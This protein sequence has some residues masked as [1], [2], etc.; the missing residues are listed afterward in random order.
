MG[1]VDGSKTRQPD[2]NSNMDAF[3]IK[4][5]CIV[6]CSDISGRTPK[7]TMS[8]IG[9]PAPEEVPGIFASGC[10]AIRGL[11]KQVVS[12]S[13][14]YDKTVG[15]DGDGITGAET[16][17]APSNFEASFEVSHAQVL[18]ALNESIMVLVWTQ[19]SLRDYGS[20]TAIQEMPGFSPPPE[21]RVAWPPGPTLG[22]AV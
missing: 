10:K 22:T 4:F 13:G 16:T 15:D 6:R 21:M 2:L 11:K 9:R 20:I 19:K 5:R 7:L 8:A 17:S 14:K 1:G 18:D 12:T 3:V